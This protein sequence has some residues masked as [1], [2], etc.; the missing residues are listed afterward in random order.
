MISPNDTQEFYVAHKTSHFSSGF[1]S[2]KDLSILLLPWQ[3]SGDG[4]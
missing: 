2:S 3:M 4:A 1:G